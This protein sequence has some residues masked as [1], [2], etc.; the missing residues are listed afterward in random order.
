MRQGLMQKMWYGLT[1]G[2]WRTW[3]PWSTDRRPGAFSSGGIAGADGVLERVSPQ[4]ALNISAWWAGL[5]LRSDC[6]GSMPFKIIERKTN[7][8]IEDH[9]VFNLLRHK[10]NAYQTG[11]EYWSAMTANYDTFGNT[12]SI[13]SRYAN[14]EPY[15]VDFIPMELLTA[16]L[17]K[18]GRPTFVYEGEQLDPDNVLHVPNFS[19][20]GYW[21][22]PTLTAANYALGMQ[23][24]GNTAAAATFKSG[25]RTGGFFLQDE[26]KGEMPPEVQ[27]DFRNKV[28]EF[29][30]PE[31]TGKWFLVPRGIIPQERAGG[32]KIDP[33][34]AEL[35]NSR[36]FG[37]EEVC[38]FLGVPPPLIGHT[39]KASSW[40]SSLDSLN[41]HL[42]TYGLMPTA[43]RYE[44]R[45]AHTLLT[46]RERNRFRVEFNMDSLLRGDIE[47][48]FKSYEIGRKVNVYSA[49]EVRAMER[50]PAREDAGGGKYIVESEIKVNQNGSTEN[51]V[52]NDQPAV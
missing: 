46:P 9:A 35:L 26:K 31:N 50:M 44:R 32:M 5:K 8:E 16:T 38:R 11:A 22:I 28:A 36:A 12:V 41:Q 47:K 45:I 19:L 7:R 25:L 3:A 13:I 29:Y 18:L 24:A 42:V 33:V 51:E 17:D 27:A 4:G 34:S 14:G 1:P 39:N 49:D 43:V 20:N 10:P 40:A 48:R 6:M 30:R 23:L 2:G 15:N 21:G 52:Q 37:I